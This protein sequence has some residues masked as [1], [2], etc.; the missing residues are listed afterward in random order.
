MTNYTAETLDFSRLDA[1]SLV[2]VD[3]EAHLATMLAKFV[4]FWDAFRA[5]DPTL[6]VFDT[7]MIESDPAVILH[8]A[9][10]FGDMLLRQEIN[11]AANS[12]RLPFA[13]GADLDLLAGTFHRTQRREI[14][15]ANELTGAP[16]IYESN[17]EYRARAQLAPEALADMGLTPGGYIFRVRT[18]FADRISHV[19]PI[20]RGNGRVELRVLGRDGD[21]TVSPALLAEIIAAFQIEEGSQS[22]DVLTVLPAEI[23][24]ITPSVTLMLPR[25]P[26]RSRVEAAAA[27]GITALGAS[28]RR[29]NAPVFREAISS[30]A[31]V[32]PVVTVRV[33]DPSI[34]MPAR[35]EVVP[36]FEAP[37]VTSE[38]L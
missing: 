34:D 3:A 9:W 36:I 7:T 18:Q 14:V 32:G 16:A 4:E 35:P 20:N 33:N 27:T 31:H 2:T 19:F 5:L 30:A 10:T 24:R 37:I 6:P 38:V 17:E 11:D 12:L 22:T 29:I 23:V 13:V 1:P 28:L 21:G 25:G 8:Q 26:D 15:P